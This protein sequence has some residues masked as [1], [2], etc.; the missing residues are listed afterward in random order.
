MLRAEHFA[1]YYSADCS[2][3][4]D[5]PL[6]SPFFGNAFSGKKITLFSI[7]FKIEPPLFYII[8]DHCPAFFRKNSG[9]CSF[10]LLSRNYVSSVC[11]SDDTLFIIVIISFFPQIFPGRYHPD[12]L[13]RHRNQPTIPFIRS[14]SP[15]TPAANA[16]AAQASVIIHRIVRTVP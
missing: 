9:H 3:A 11:R 4:K 1:K 6:L 15:A 8:K 2:T 13:F 10:L 16:H 7:Y 12:G 14:L 5:A